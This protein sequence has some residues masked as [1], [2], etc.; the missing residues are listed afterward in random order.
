MDRTFN[1]NQQYDRPGASRISGNPTEIMIFC[2][3]VFVDG[4]PELR[5]KQH[6]S[7]V[8]GISGCLIQIFTETNGEQV[9]FKIW[10]TS[11]QEI[12]N[13]STHFY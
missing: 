13:C 8:N 7:I 9:Q 11:E 6:I 12:V 2:C 1:F 4:Q 10:I 5:G 3:F